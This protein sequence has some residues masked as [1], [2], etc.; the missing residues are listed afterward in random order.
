M[1]SGC[2]FFSEKVYANRNLLSKDPE[3]LCKRVNPDPKKKQ[4]FAVAGNGRWCD[5]SGR[6]TELLLTG[7]P[8]VFLLLSLGF[9]IADERVGLVVGTG[10]LLDEGDPVEDVVIFDQV[11]REPGRGEFPRPGQRTETVLQ[12]RISR[13]GPLQ[14]VRPVDGQVLRLEFFIILKRDRV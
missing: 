12:S 2:V 8:R 5:G 13:L 9:C 11:D 6:R 4:R 1:Q 3:K 14:V 10:F 7:L